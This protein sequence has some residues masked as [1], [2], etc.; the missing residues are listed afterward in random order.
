MN[1]G[2]L[3]DDSGAGAAIIWLEAR[4]ELQEMIFKGLSFKQ[5]RSMT[6]DMFPK[7]NDKR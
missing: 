6:N 3:S 1:S 2:F 7:I 5:S 4:H